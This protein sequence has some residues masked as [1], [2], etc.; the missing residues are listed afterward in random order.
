MSMTRLGVKQIIVHPS[1]GKF[2]SH[3]FI[4]MNGVNNIPNESKQIVEPFHSILIDP[5]HVHTRCMHVHTSDV[6]LVIISGTADLGCG[7]VS[8]HI[9]TF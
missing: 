6:S 9:G 5:V 8:L 3:L 2:C 4:D 1:D 7:R